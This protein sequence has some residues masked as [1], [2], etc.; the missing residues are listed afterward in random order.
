M[1]ATSPDATADLTDVLERVAAEAHPLAADD[2]VA[3]PG[4]GPERFGLALCELDGTEH[5]AG[6]ADVGFP[7]QSV[8]KVFTLTAALR[9]VGEDVFQRVGREPSG[10]PFDSLVQL[11]R[12]HGVPRN[13][14]INAG[15]VVVTDVLVEA[16]G[17]PAAARAAVTDLLSD[18]VGERLEPDPEVVAEERAGA[19]L[20]TAMGHLMRSFDNFTH[21]VDEVVDAYGHLCAL[22]VTAR[23]LAR[24]ARFLANDGVDPR[25]GDRV[26][27][28]P[29]ARRVN[30]VMM[31]C[32]TYDAAGQFAYDVGFPCKSGVA[33]AVMG[34]VPGRFG[35]CAWSPP[36]D[37]AGNSRAGRVALHLLSE[38]LDLSLL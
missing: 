23:Q 3:Q 37:T 25:T 1:P 33:G 17:S 26:L 29:L 22:T 28:E 18:L 11:E 7:V 4:A 9:L 13:P 12:E 2:E 27:D 8:V 36:L 35:V 21:P 16:T 5:V 38:R 34:D 15:A 14:F 6:D 31:T 32:G 20:N 30:A 19:A 24:A 10:D